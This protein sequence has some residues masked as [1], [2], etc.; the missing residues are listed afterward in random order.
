MRDKKIHNYLVQGHGSP[1]FLSV[2]S[3]TAKKFYPGKR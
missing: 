2:D 1:L 3:I